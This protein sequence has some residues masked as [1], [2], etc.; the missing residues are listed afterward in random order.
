MARSNSR[1]TRWL[2][3]LLIALVI[4]AGIAYEIYRRNQPDPVTLSGY[5]SGE[6]MPFLEDPEVRTILQKDYKISLNIHKSGSL[7]MSDAADLETRNFLWPSGQAAIDRYKA[8][9]GEP[10]REAVLLNSPLVL[11]TY[12]SIAEVL[13]KDT[14]ALAELLLSGRS[15]QE[16]GVAQ[17]TGPVTLHAADPELT[18]SG[19]LW[20]VLLGSA[21]NDDLTLTETAVPK[22]RED[23]RR[24]FQRMGYLESTTEDLFE[25]YLRTGIG[26]KPLVVGYENQLAA[27]ALNHPEAYARLKDELVMI[28]P[29]PTI[30]TSHVFMALDDEGARLL[31]ALQDER[32]QAIAGARYGFRIGAYGAAAEAVDYGVTGWQE[33]VTDVISLPSYDVLEDLINTRE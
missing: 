7:A 23:V 4:G 12:K 2:G 22:V 33:Q 8:K 6:K 17:L 19:Q 16:L 32:L 18:N 29:E 30:W 20:A 9:V 25:L 26:N 27:F 15:W 5:V 28:Y 14:A 13:P 21:L 1:L 31:T 11:Y 3:L 10:Y 24:I